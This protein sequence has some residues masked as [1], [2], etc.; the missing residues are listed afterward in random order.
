MDA[1]EAPCLK[2]NKAVVEAEDK[3]GWVL[4]DYSG[5]GVCNQDIHAAAKAE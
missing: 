2:G 1:D 4:A 3:N 5:E